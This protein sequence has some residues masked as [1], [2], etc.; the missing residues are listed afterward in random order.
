MQAIGVLAPLIRQLGSRANPE[1][2]PAVAVWAFY[3]GNVCGL[4]HSP[5]ISCAASCNALD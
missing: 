2:L 5:V 3:A 1:F 4:C